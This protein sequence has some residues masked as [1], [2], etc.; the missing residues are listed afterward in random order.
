MTALLTLYACTIGNTCGEGTYSEGGECLPDASS[1]TDADSDADSDS[2][3]DAD[4]DT[5]SDVNAGE[6]DGGFGGTYI[7]QGGNDYFCS[8]SLAFTIDTD[9]T[10]EGETKCAYREIEDEMMGDLEGRDDDGALSLVWY[11]KW[12]GD[13]YEIEMSGSVDDGEAYLYAEQSSLGT[14]EF[15]AEGDANR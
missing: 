12:G 4:S 9:G 15:S 14:G 7:S 8:G 10:L 2:D 13:T 5:D 11:A 1:E 6:Y 3:S